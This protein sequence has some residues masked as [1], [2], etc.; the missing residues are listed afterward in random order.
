MGTGPGRGI[1]QMFIISGLFLWVE[2]IVAYANPR[3]RNLESE[4]PNEPQ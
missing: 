1:G 4:I 3:I 2:S